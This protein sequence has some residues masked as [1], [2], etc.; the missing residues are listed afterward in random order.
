MDSLTIAVPLYN[1][2]AGIENLH[3]EL[4]PVVKEI[5][6]YRDVGILLV[7]DGSSDN[8][9]DLL[10][11]FFLETKNCKIIKHT[12]NLNLDGFFRTSI[13]TCETDLIVFLDSDCTFDPTY[14]IKMLDLLDSETDIVNGSPYHPEGGVQGVNKARLALSYFSNSLY[15]A[16]TRTKLHTFTSIFKL[17]RLN[18]IR[19][20]EI[21]NKGFVSVAEVFIKA[22]NEGSSVKELPCILTIR[23][24]GESKIR[25]FQS[26]INH[27]RFMITILKK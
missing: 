6:K 26:I 21:Q 4:M 17:Y 13:K 16:I 7:N 10:E 22:I 24:L 1:E 5:R 25:I 8:T 11:K 15:R 18:S 12:S 14:I 19:N 3:N 9:Q 2:E 23:E 20:I 27:I